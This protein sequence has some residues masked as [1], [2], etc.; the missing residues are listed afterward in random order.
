MR[1]HFIISTLLLA[2]L[3]TGAANAQAGGEA[4]LIACRTQQEI[5]QVMGSDARFRPDGC[6]ALTITRIRSGDGEVCVLNF[7][8]A[9]EEGVIE[10]LR[11][12]ATQTQWWV[13]CAKIAPM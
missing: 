3:E 8:A 4:T 10:R 7:E 5:E 6:R 13:D 2:I 1:V 9:G 11:D 12:V